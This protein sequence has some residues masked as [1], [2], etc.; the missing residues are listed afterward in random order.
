MV[1]EAATV[2]SPVGR[3]LGTGGIDIVFNV[4]GGVEEL[5]RSMITGKRTATCR[6]VSGSGFSIGLLLSESIVGSTTSLKTSG[7]SEAIFT[8]MCSDN[9]TMSLSLSK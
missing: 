6:I 1:A 9:V 2:L 8:R 5:Q 4:T 7:T 3:G